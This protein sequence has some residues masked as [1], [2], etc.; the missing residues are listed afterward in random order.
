MQLNSEDGTAWHG[1][2]DLRKLLY[3]I[4]L[5]QHYLLVVSASNI[6]ST[7]Y[8]VAVALIVLKFLSLNEN[9]QEEGKTSQTAGNIKGSLSG[10]DRS[11]EILSRMSS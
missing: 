2:T 1:I 11:C 10:M 4:N 5:V 7:A 3:F 9:F 8:T 6:L